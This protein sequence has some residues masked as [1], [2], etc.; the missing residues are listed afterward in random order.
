MDILKMRELERYNS[1]LD[2][3]QCR[4]ALE[5]LQGQGC[6]SP[7]YIRYTEISA[8]KESF[9]GKLWI[10]NMVDVVRVDIK[11]SK[12]LPGSELTIVMEM[13]LY[14]F[15]YRFTPA[16][17]FI[18][19]LTLAGLIPTGFGVLFLC[20][21]IYDFF[22]SSRYN[23]NRVTKKLWNDLRLSYPGIGWMNRQ[24]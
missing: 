8:E 14:S 10:T 20:G 12:R 9:H 17:F 5:N 18:L 15:M 3:S 19:P 23:K 24:R 4:L 1:E 7:G 22:H 11:G 21:F 13:G 2:I 6:L 16:F